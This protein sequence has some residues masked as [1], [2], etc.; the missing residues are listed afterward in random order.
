MV[1]LADR[2]LTL[3][4]PTTLAAAVANVASTAIEGLAGMQ[5]L[6]LEAIFVRAGGG[7]TCKV[8]VQTS[9]DAGGTWVDIANFA[10]TTTTASKLHVVHLFPATPMT[11]A[12]APGSAAL[13]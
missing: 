7:T 8:W 3:L 2:R 9:F 13:T 10:F 5:A 1:A 4:A 11:A 12:T 6:C